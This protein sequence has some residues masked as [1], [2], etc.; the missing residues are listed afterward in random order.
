MAKKRGR[1]RITEMYFGPNEEQAV[2]NFLESTDQKERN[3]IFKQQLAAPL[4]KMIESIIRRYKLYRKGISFEELHTDTLSFLMTKAHKFENSKGNKSYSYYGTICKH[5]I[6]GLLMKDDKYIKQVSSYE[7]MAP[8]LENKV[9]L[10]YHIDEDLSPTTILINQILGKIKLTL[11]QGEFNHPS[12]TKRRIP[13]K[14]KLTENERKVG[15]MLIEILSNWEIT[16]DD[17]DGSN[18]FN[19]ISILSTLR[20]GTNLSTK[21]IRSAMKRYKELYILLKTSLNDDEY[22]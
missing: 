3:E 19:K 16:F 1:K 20:D 15:E 12:I 13:E 7:D 4:D 21:D 11:N 2:I 9:E 10:S 18:K 17:M 8:T 5:Y 6:L 14:N 22:S